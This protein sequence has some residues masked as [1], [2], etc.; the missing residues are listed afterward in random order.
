MKRINGTRRHLAFGC[1]S[2]VLLGS[3]AAARAQGTAP[4]WSPTKPIELIVSV[5]PGS[6]VDITA[7]L[8]AEKLPGILGQ[9]VVVINRPGASGLIAASAVARAD[10]DGHTLLVGSNTML[11][12]PHTLPKTSSKSVDVIRDLAPVIT[13][14]TSPLVVMANPG[15]GVKTAPDL[16]AYLKRNP[17]LPYATAGSGSPF[18]FAGEMF[19]A[20]TQTQLTHV[21]YKG[22]MPAVSDVVGGQVMLTFGALGGVA[23]FV[24]SGKLVALAVGEKRRTKLLP[25]VPTLRESGI[26]IDFTLFFPVFA[27]AA[28]P[29]SVQSRL[30]AAMNTVLQ[31]PDVKSR[32]LEVGVESRGGSI[33]E[34]KSMILDQYQ[35]FERLALEYRIR[36]D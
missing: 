28:T 31:M 19:K 10:P 7:R 2:V 1:L 3:A 33:D 11:G 16:V 32:L 5:A 34:A 26:P 8:L 24:E 25:N 13:T 9:P 12:A 36:S 35:V 14:A 18:H 30:N 21:P 23:Q 4:S 29:L 6:S 20:A 15:L 27:P 17:G 22:V